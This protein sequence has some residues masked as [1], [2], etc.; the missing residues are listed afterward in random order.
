MAGVDCRGGGRRRVAVS[1]KEASSSWRL[2][3][4]CQVVVDDRSA[5]SIHCRHCVLRIGGLTRFVAL[6]ILPFFSTSIFFYADDKL[7]SR[8]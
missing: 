3:G 2:D 7:Y 1:G 8:V 4:R 5:A 6:K